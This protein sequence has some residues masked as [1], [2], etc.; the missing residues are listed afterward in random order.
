MKDNEMNKTT[1]EIPFLK[2]NCIKPMYS[3]GME[4]KSKCISHQKKSLLI[5]MENDLM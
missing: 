1:I 4:I 2:I 5:R 3:S